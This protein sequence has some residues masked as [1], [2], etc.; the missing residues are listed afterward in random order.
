MGSSQMATISDERHP[1]RSGLPFAPILG[2]S[3]TRRSHDATSRCG[4]TS[5]QPSRWD[6]HS[7]GQPGSGCAARS[8]SPNGGCRSRLGSCLLRCTV[9]RG[10]PP[11]P[12]CCAART[13]TSTGRPGCRG[14]ERLT[15]DE[16]S[17]SLVPPGAGRARHVRRSLI[18]RSVPD[19]PPLRA[20]PTLPP[21]LP[22]PRS[23]FGSSTV[24]RPNPLTW[25]SSLVSAKSQGALGRIRT[26]AHGSGGRC[27]IP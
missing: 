24:S 27:S 10:R 7:P 14:S 22:V 5:R 8:R 12:V 16:Q 6:R 26:C 15:A 21:Q 3:T 19:Q 9:T 2:R 20:P 17:T 13:C 1:S 25:T 18:Q 4:A 11:S 23:P